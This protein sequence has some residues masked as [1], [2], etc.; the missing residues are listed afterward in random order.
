MTTL[1]IFTLFLTRRDG[2]AS[3]ASRRGAQ[4]VLQVESFAPTLSTR[5]SSSPPVG[6][7]HRATP[8]NRDSHLHSPLLESPPP[9]AGSD[10]NYPY[11]KLRPLGNKAQVTSVTVETIFNYDDAKPAC[12]VSP[13][14]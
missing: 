6:L 12:S 7:Q 5:G 1:A 14:S 9:C 2:R 8:G 10:D 4:P 11:D 13:P 3:C